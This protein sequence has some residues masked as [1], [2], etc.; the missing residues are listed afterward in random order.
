M[1]NV[2]E[3]LNDF[4]GVK[5][6]ERIAGQNE[7]VWQ[8]EN[9]Q[10]MDFEL[11]TPGHPAGQQLC[12]HVELLAET[13][14]IVGIGEEELRGLKHFCGVFR[15][16]IMAGGPSGRLMR[17]AGHEDTPF[18]ACEVLAFMLNRCNEIVTLAIEHR[19]DELAVTVNI[20][21]GELAIKSALERIGLIRQCQ[22][23][24]Q[25]DLFFKDRFGAVRTS[26]EEVLRELA[27][28]RQRLINRVFG[29]HKEPSLFGYG[30]E[31]CPVAPKHQR[32]QFLHID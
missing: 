2:P 26:D 30:P 15:S 25:L 10:R 31:H 6:W 19:D 11:C 9:I 1:T 27:Q 5:I 17:H 21:S 12:P 20:Q 24:L 28:A 4:L 22:L 23:G 13:A 3:G 18:R 7:G 32:N 29:R 16:D 14:A 8:A